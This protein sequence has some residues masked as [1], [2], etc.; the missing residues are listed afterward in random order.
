MARLFSAL[1]MSALLAVSGTAFAADEMGVPAS[2][3]AN[4]AAPATS[5]TS[6]AQK[7]VSA[8]KAVTVAAKHHGPKKHGKKH[9]HK[10]HGHKHHAKKAAAKTA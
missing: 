3:A 1:V 10:K 7:T 5:G 4:T 6:V 8:D 9:G 2:D